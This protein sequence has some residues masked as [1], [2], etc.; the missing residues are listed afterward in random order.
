MIYNTE[1]YGTITCK[2]EL[3]FS[4]IATIVNTVKNIDDVCLAYMTTD[5]YLLKILTDLEIEDELNLEKYD[6][7]FSDGITEIV[8]SDSIKNLDLLYRL[9]SESK[10]IENQIGAFLDRFADAL[11]KVSKKMPS[12]KKMEEIALSVVNVQGQKNDN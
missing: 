2:E 12:K 6:E 11:E 3:S 7:L 4:E 9:I 5:L 10:K 1:K 8:H